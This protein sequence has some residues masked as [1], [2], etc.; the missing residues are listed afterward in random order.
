MTPHLY[1]IPKDTTIYIYSIDGI[2]IWDDIL[3]GRFKE[4]KTDREAYLNTKDKDVIYHDFDG[5]QWYQAI[6]GNVYYG[7][8]KKFL[9]EIL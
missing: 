7:I 9:V 1:L 8:E 5:Q 3:S 2:S 4:C 6:V